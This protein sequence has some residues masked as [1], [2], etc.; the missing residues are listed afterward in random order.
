MNTLDAVEQGDSHRKTVIVGG[1]SGIGLTVARL[2]RAR[3]ADV[4]V[5]DLGAS[6]PESASG[7]VDVEYQQADV[8]DPETLV[9]AFGEISRGGAE[10]EVG[11]AHIG[12]IFVSAGITLPTPI[13]QVTMEAAG[14][15]LLINLLG[16]VN[17]IQ[18]SLEHLGDGASIVLAASAAAYTGGGYVGGS[19]Y[20][21]SKAGV[22]GLT[23][24]AARELA[25]RGVRVN[26]V[27]PGATAT[28]MVGEDPEVVERLASKALLNRLATPED[29]AE[30]VLYLWSKAAGYI[31]GATLDIN[32]GSHLG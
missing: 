7:L 8:L 30:G 20:G 23:R 26:C 27:A 10:S 5:I 9:R 6:M 28:S 15:C 29:I 19:V 17:T 13:D 3:G 4:A 12:S 22:I 24:G 1:A 11:A 25:G 21:A 31:T 14:R 2:A 16:S 32:G 18:A